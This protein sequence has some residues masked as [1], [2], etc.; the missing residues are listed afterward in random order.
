M[1]LT[2]PGR[3][4]STDGEWAVV[5]LD[6]APRRASL[7]V[8]PDAAVGDCVLVAAGLVLEVLDDEALA[9]LRRLLDPPASIDKGG[10]E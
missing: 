7:A 3:I 8:V 10:T 2:S 6:G 1:C 5:E 4:L 9:D